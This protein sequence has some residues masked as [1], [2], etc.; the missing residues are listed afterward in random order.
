MTNRRPYMPAVTALVVLAGL[1]G[2]IVTT[3]HTDNDPAPA[4]T[5][6]T[7]TPRLNDAVAV[8]KP[9]AVPVY[10]PDGRAVM[11]VFNNAG[12]LTCDWPDAP[13]PTEGANN[14]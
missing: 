7:T 6:V 13:A 2:L 9:Y 1:V 12:A 8:H 11:C 10:L 3:D 4:P 5:P 14:G